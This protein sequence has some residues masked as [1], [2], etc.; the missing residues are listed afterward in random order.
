MA[1]VKGRVCER[2]T[3][4]TKKMNLHEACEAGDMERVR[5]IVAGGACVRAARAPD[6]DTPLHIVCRRSLLDLATFLYERGGDMTVRNADGSAP[7]H[8]LRGINQ[9]H[10]PLPP[11][12]MDRRHIDVQDGRGR[13]LLYMRVHDE[14]G[15]LLLASGADP[16]IETVTQDSVF[17]IFLKWAYYYDDRTAYRTLQ[18]YVRECDVGKT[19]GDVTLMHVAAAHADVHLVRR[20]I[21]KGV[22]VNATTD[23][24]D[25][26]LMECL[27]RCGSNKNR[28]DVFFALIRAGAFFDC[29]NDD[30]F[31]PLHQACRSYHPHII[32]KL[33][34][35]GADIHAETVSGFT[36]LHCLLLSKSRS[37]SI[38]DEL[39][40]R[41]ARRDCKTKMHLAC[42]QGRLNDVRKC[43]RANASA[44]SFRDIH[45]Y[46]PLMYA[47]TGGHADIVRVVLDHGAASIESI[48]MNPL[49]I[50]CERGHTNVVNALIVHP[51][52]Y[53]KLSCSDKTNCFNVAY[54]NGH[55]STVRLLF[56]ANIG[57]PSSHPFIVHD[58]ERM[59]PFQIAMSCSLSYSTS[60][61]ILHVF[62]SGGHTSEKIRYLRDQQH[63]ERVFKHPSAH[64]AATE[65]C[66]A[67]RP[68]KESVPVIAFAVRR[69]YERQLQIAPRNYAP[70]LIADM[71]EPMFSDIEIVY[72]SQHELMFHYTHEF[73]VHCDAAVEWMEQMM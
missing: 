31:S 33:I 32:K 57:L 63:L 3:S 22:N 1:Q 25:T 60:D 52:F 71:H 6:G 68:A 61:A 62:A 58:D 36:P 29:K 66:V 11:W 55:E 69:R 5:A 28:A 7:F 53:K 40:R 56:R 67:F 13:T 10:F 17:R 70:T 42:E 47:C 16:H 65:W 59:E 4:Q 14:V 38:V 54:R 8:L 64:V 46:T 26:P 41:G 37:S 34:A 45:G 9:T 72:H 73:V 51:S 30:G 44:T 20:C 21:R 12:M 49:Y 39:I 27:S 2:R 18:S 19:F 35:Y 50:A 43:I 15:A 48:E 24:G 23:S